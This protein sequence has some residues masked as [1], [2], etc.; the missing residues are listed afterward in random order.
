MRIKG[1]V[2]ARR[3]KKKYF[4]I[5]KSYYSD[6]GNKWRQVKQQVEK[7]L[8]SSYRDRKKKKRYFKSLWITRIN[9]LSREFGMSYS[10]FI[11]GLKK[12]GIAIDRKILAEMATQDENSFRKLAEISKAAQVKQ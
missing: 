5:A 4:R 8:V 3:R 7:A 2:H 12:S 1:G 10:R 6:K 11:S 9:S